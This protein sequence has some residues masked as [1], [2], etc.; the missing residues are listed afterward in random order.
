MFILLLPAVK[1]ALIIFISI[2]A[3]VIFNYKII[4]LSSA[5]FILTDL[6]SLSP[7]DYIVIPGAGNPDNG[8]NFFFKSR[9]AAATIAHRHFPE[10]KILCI[11]RKDHYRYNE[12]EAMKTALLNNG[13]QDSIILVDTAGFNTFKMLIQVK[14]N[15]KGRMLFISQQMHL[16]RIIFSAG[17][18]K[19]EAVGYEVPQPVAGRKR[20]YFRYREIISSLRMTA[21][22]AGYKISKMF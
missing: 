2:P 11:G 4:A 9:I 10:A 21:S 19:I 1:K 22:L 20:K 15:Y 18:L 12:P 8:K 17:R 13:I 6:N 3:L 16:Q 7:P 14:E 5:P